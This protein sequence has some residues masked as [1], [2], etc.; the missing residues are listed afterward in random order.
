MKSLQTQAHEGRAAVGTAA[1]P[2]AI[3]HGMSSIQGWVQVDIESIVSTAAR[4]MQRRPVS[5]R[6]KAVVNALRLLDEWA[7]AGHGCA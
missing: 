3:R 2:W 1:V 6:E 7:E 5:Q 4:I